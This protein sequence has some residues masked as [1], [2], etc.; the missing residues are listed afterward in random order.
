MELTDGAD[1]RAALEASCLRGAFLNV[2]KVIQSDEVVTV[3]CWR[4]VKAK[5]KVRRR[6]RSQSRKPRP[7]GNGENDAYLAS[8]RLAGGLLGTGHCRV[9]LMLMEVMK[10]CCGCRKLLVGREDVVCG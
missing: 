2:S 10:S 4:R 1:L 8:S 3:W 6:L 7:G 5:M 9:V